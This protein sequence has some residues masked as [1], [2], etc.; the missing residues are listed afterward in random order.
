MP[1]TEFAEELQQRTQILIDKTK[2][3]IMQS[4]LKYKEY[5]DRKAKAAP[6]SEQDFCFILQPKADNQGSKI[7]FREYRWIGPY[8]IEK[9]LPND[10]YI[11]RRLN[12]NKTQILH[13]IRL[14]KFVPNTP[15]E[16]KYAK[17][18]LQPDDEIIIPQDDLYTI[19]WEADFDYHVFEPRR[20]DKTNEELRTPDS[21]ADV[22]TSDY[23]IYDNADD[24]AVRPGTAT[25]RDAPI[26][27]DEHDVSENAARD[28]QSSEIER[29]RTATSRNSHNGGNTPPSSE[30]NVNDVTNELEGEKNSPNEGD[31]ITVPGI[32]DNLND[33]E[34]EKGNEVSSPRGG[35][36]NL[37]PNPTPNYTDEYRY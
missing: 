21:D 28:E 30:K 14:K 10:N 23:V 17:E 36:Y 27:H 26:M 13:R 5:Y 4:Y 24:N 22:T 7:P 35:K 15:L 33:A 37:R 8:R 1:T 2:Q 18:K 11:V 31:D 16:D 25:S 6:L 3:N 12:T 34:N 29:P 9:A 32:S 19:S 20:D